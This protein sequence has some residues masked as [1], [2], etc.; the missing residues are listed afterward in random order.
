MVKYYAVRKGHKT[1]IFTT[2]GQVEPLVK[3]FPGAQ[4]KSFPNLELAR[5]YLDSEGSIVPELSSSASSPDVS[6]AQCEDSQYDVVIYTDGSSDQVRAGYG[7]VFTKNNRVITTFKGPLPLDI[8]PAQ[9]NNQSE[10][11][12][13]LIALKELKKHKQILIKSDSNYSI[14]SLTEW[15]HGWI[16]N[17]WKTSKGMDVLNKEL[18][19]DILHELDSRNLD[20]KSI[21]FEHV[22]AHCGIEFNELADELA[23]EGR[24]EHNE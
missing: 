24:L 1:G 16:R 11:Y 20:E 5:S 21:K 23:N 4:H 3:G 22:R 12:A 7:V 9:T 15:C 8:Y 10:L 19:M 18:I 6:H 14:K 17:G 2:W 13:I